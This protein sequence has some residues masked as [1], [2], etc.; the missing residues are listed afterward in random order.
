[1]GGEVEGDFFSNQIKILRQ[2]L[3][4]FKENDSLKKNNKIK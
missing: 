2:Y 1:M 4:I 3:L